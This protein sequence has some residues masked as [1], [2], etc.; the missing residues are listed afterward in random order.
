MIIAYTAAV[1]VKFIYTVMGRG[2]VRVC[3]WG[4]GGFF[5]QGYMQGSSWNASLIKERTCLNGTPDRLPL[6]TPTPIP[7]PKIAPTFNG[8]SPTKL[9]KKGSRHHKINIKLINAAT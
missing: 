5:Q 4:R 8:P 7:H 1:F 9:G 3:V 2:C 6:P